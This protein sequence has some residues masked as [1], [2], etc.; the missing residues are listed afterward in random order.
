MLSRQRLNSI[1]ENTNVISIEPILTPKELKEKLPLDDVTKEQIYKWR[2][3]ID[4]IISGRDQRI[5]VILGPCSIH[6][7][8]SAIEYAKELAELRKIFGKKVCIVMR[9]YFEKP[10]TTIGWKGLIND[11][12][13]DGTYDI[14]TGLALAREILLKINQLGVP[15]G[16]EFLDVFTPQYYAD[17]VSWGAIGART[18]E[19]QLHRE[20]ASGL[21]MTIGFKNG[22]DGSIEIAAEA[23][24]C[25]QTPHVFLGIDDEGK[26]SIVKTSGNKSLQVI[27][28]GSAEGPNY[29]H[30]NIVRVNK[31]LKSKNINTRILVDCSHGNSGKSYKNQPLVLESV[32]NQIENGAENICGFMIESHI[33]EGAQKHKVENGKTGLL[34]GVS[35]TD[36]CI[37]L[38]TTYKMLERIVNA[39]FN[40][41]L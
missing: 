33:K 21:S 15:T 31:I 11:P 5:L 36:E 20:L 9:V 30:V 19:S 18:T 14:N 38:N 16:C 4:D 41:F 28:R 22:T 7:A 29:D 13:L 34:Y 32:M 37:N 1:V 23:I 17:L 25:A 10:R 8:E 24:Q 26:A 2:Q 12:N 39:R 6:D 27:L 35:I 3:E 40:Y